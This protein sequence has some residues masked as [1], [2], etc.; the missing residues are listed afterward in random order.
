MA[1]S[2]TIGAVTGA[3]VAAALAA[4]VAAVGAV[5]V[6]VAEALPSPSSLILVLDSCPPEGVDSSP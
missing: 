1:A 3:V 6:A 2:S 5:A 4:A